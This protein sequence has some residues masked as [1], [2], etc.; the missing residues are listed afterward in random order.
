M[1]EGKSPSVSDLWV[2]VVFF[3]IGET[4]CEKMDLSGNMVEESVIP[5]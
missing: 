3:S 1:K 5:V 2:L 4:F